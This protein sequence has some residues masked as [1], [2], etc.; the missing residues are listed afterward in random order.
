MDTKRS[1][2]SE[3]ESIKSENILEF[4]VCLLNGEVFELQTEQVEKGV[5]SQHLRDA[6]QEC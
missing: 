1:Y 2:F 4:G 5:V 6:C 3:L